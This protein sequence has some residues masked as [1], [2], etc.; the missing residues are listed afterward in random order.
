MD[1]QRISQFLKT[2]APLRCFSVIDSTNLHAK[3]WA[4]D[5]APF[6]AVVLADRQTAGRGR[7]GRSFFSPQG[8]LYLSIVL[9]P[10]QQPG[11]LT[12]LAAVAVREAV[13]KHDRHDLNIKWVNDLLLKG[14]KVC[15]ILVEG[16]AEGGGLSHAVLGIGLNTADAAFPDELAKTAAVLKVADRERLAADIIN[17]VTAGLNHMP[18]HM[19]A[20]RAHCL[21]LGRQVAF[22]HEGQQ[23]TGI[24]Q[25][26]DD[27]G[28]LLVQ[29]PD[30]PL[31]LFAGEVSVRGVDGGYF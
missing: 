15:G 7:L 20:Y 10:Q 19:D 3:Q 9:P 31:R 26:V 5:G 30:G 22:T 29:T 24:A 27:S 8:G 17:R 1:S 13:L 16:L 11:Q 12:T 2:P 25:D 18:A 28:A 4:K 14:K 6:G 21:T 23:R